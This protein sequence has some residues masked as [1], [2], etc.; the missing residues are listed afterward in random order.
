MSEEDDLVAEYGTHFIDIEMPSLRLKLRDDSGGRPDINLGKADLD[1]LLLTAIDVAN[2]ADQ[3][4]NWPGLLALHRSLC[5]W[6]RY[7]KWCIKDHEAQEWERA[8]RR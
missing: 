5:R 8:T 6:A 4:G 2:S 3:F 7:A 1:R